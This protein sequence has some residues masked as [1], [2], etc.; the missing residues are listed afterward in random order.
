M[1]KM[2]LIFLILMITLNIFHVYSFSIIKQKTLL[3]S[4]TKNKNLK[5]KK[6]NHMILNMNMF[7]RMFRVVTSNVN[8]V[9]RSLEDPEKI[10]IQAID[11]MQRDLINVRQSY[12]EITATQKRLEKQKETAELNANEWYRRAQIA[13]NKNDDDLAREALSKR[14]IQ[15]DIIDGLTKSLTTQTNAIDRLYTSMMDLDNKISEAKRE[16]EVMIARAK[17]AKTSVKVNDMLNNVG[18]SGSSSMDAFERMKEKVESLEAKAEVSSELALSS[19]GTNSSLEEKFRLLEGNSK[20]DDELE[21]MKI[22]LPS[23]KQSSKLPELPSSS[24]TASSSSS[25]QS[26][27]D[28]EYERLKKEMGKR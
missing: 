12:A 22:Q 16:K 17:T 4:S 28:L 11:D 25:S 7:D 20:I 2:V 27:L 26:A 14:Q 24:S 1:S 6:L 5:I 9:I 18:T 8:N 19:V 13:L 3:L 10:I 23:G 21:L 15:L